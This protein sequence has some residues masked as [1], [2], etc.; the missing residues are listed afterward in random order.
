MAR[1][2]R[3]IALFEVIQSTKEKKAPPPNL[4][5][6]SWWFKSRP[7]STPHSTATDIASPVAPQL[8][9]PVMRE[10]PLSEPP[11]DVVMPIEIIA[12]PPAIRPAPRVGVLDEAVS[13]QHR[14]IV[15]YD[16]FGAPPPAAVRVGMDRD[17][18]IFKLQ[19][20]Y[21]SALVTAFGLCVVL[22]L[23]FIIGRAVSRGPHAASA[24]VSIES[25]KN[26]QAFPDVL[27]NID[28]GERTSGNLT[29]PPT[30]RAIA[31][32]TATTTQ[33]KPAAAGN[34]PS[35]NK[36]IVG[37]QYVL[38]QSYPDEEDARKAC[39]AL[40]K[41]GILCTV[42][43]NLP[44]WGSSWY[45]V[46]GGTGFERTKNNPQFDQYVKA[47]RDVGAQFATSSK[48][49]KFE[50]RPVGWRDQAAGQ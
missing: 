28:G 29:D 20:T 3:A 26:G 2:K 32:G 30:P 10:L 6:P 8:E 13:N 19:V 35:E 1:S 27:K 37:M 40:K 5:T 9:S 31:A 39:D 36:R 12:P 25:L 4:S 21:T 23:A 33:S 43:R 42:E 18:Q 49:K 34:P 11:E 46:V 50:P 7:Q 17:R 24:S 48:F 47:I 22:L 44:G 16:D 45:C 41:N 38:V 14:D 15:D